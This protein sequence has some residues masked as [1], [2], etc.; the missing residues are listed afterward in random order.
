MSQNLQKPQKIQG[1]EKTKKNP[2]KFS[3]KLNRMVSIRYY[4]KTYELT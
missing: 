4:R 1:K 2:I 3:E